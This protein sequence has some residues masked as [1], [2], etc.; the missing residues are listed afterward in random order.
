MKKP[1]NPTRSGSKKNGRKSGK[2]NVL[3]T[4]KHVQPNGENAPFVPTS[5]E[6]GAMSEEQLADA[7]TQSHKQVEDSI[8]NARQ[9]AGTALMAALRAGACLHEVHRLVGKKR[10][11]PWVREHCPYLHIAT[12][13]RWKSLAQKFAHVRKPEEILTVRQAYVAVGMWP[14]APANKK[15]T[16]DLEKVPDFTGADLVAGVKSMRAFFDASFAQMDFAALEVP[17]REELKLELD[18]L[19]TTITKVV[20]RMV[21]GTMKQAKARV[22]RTIKGRQS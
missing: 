16:P 4:V 8:I 7:I 10:W 12:A 3:A 9:H 13:Y 15:K 1:A 17:V 6:L 19:L 20:D 11:G 18:G 2:A 5:E 14:E 22:A 21:A